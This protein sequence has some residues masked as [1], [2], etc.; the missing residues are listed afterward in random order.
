MGTFNEY[1]KKSPGPLIC[2]LITGKNIYF[3]KL[4]VLC[5]F[6]CQRCKI[7]TFKNFSNIFPKKI[8]V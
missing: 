6:L 4:D 3:L 7:N 2:F 1:F 8:I 5:F